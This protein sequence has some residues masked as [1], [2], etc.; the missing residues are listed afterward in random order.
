MARRIPDGENQH[1][2]CVTIACDTP[3]DDTYVICVVVTRKYRL[4]IT[5]RITV[6]VA[7]ISK[8]EERA[9]RGCSG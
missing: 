9:R 6:K 2:Q 8:E 7:D 1:N 4:S 3:R 5:I